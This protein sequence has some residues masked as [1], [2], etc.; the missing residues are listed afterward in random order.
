MIKTDHFLVIFTVVTI[1]YDIQIIYICHIFMV[2]ILQKSV[3]LCIAS[4][5]WVQW[6]HIGSVK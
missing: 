2:K 1:T 5:F 6:H 4:L 3:I